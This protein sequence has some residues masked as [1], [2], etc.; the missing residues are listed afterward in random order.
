MSTYSLRRFV[1]NQ[2]EYDTEQSFVRDVEAHL[3]YLAHFSPDEIA[4]LFRSEGIKGERTAACRCPVSNYLKR[5]TG[6]RY[7]TFFRA[8]QYN[9]TE[10]RAFGPSV[11]LPESV[12]DFIVC[13]DDY[14]YTD[15]IETEVAPWSS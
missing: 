9:E 15:L 7:A 3:W 2:N 4:D 1:T 13:F 8:R 10:C 6:V 12:R 11:D 5:E 14:K